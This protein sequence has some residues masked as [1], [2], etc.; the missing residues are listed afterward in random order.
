MS[1]QFSNIFLLQFKAAIFKIEKYLLVGGITIE[2]Q[3]FI[4]HLTNLQRIFNEYQ[5]SLALL[6]L[7][8]DTKGLLLLYSVCI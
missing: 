5:F 8:I 1:C 3:L 4:T 6:L 2:I 7:C